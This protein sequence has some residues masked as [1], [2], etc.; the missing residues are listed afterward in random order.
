MHVIDY[1]EQVTAGTLN[2]A[3][4][5][6]DALHERV[7]KLVTLIVGGAG[8]VGVYALGKVG[9]IGAIIQVLPLSALAC[10]WLLIAG[11][12]LLRG[13]T[14][15]ELKAGST[16]SSL[17]QTFNRRWSTVEGENLESQALDLVRWDQLASVDLQIIDFCRG[18]T[19]RSKS[20]DNAYKALVFSP[21]VAVFFLLLAYRLK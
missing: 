16:S 11:V 21:L 5:T 9:A 18:A 14:S 6:Y 3:K 2:E 20:L 17:T 10:W 15:L 19:L 7:H 13:A 8:G 4:S 12:L 1:V